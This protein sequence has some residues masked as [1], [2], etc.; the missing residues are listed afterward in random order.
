MSGGGTALRHCEPSEAIQNLSAEAAWIASSQG[1]L[2]MTAGGSHTLLDVWHMP[3]RRPRRCAVQAR[4]VGDLDLAAE[5][6]EARALIERDGRR[7]IEGA[8]VY[9]DAAEVARP[10]DF[11]RAV[12]Q[13]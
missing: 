12:H 5:R 11:E 4:V 13:E 1:L 10:C 8:G 7:M 6:A 3:R 2:T 9:P